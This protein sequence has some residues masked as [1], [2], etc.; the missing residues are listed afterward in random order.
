MDLNRKRE[1]D[2]KSLQKEL[3][4]TRADHGKVLGEVKRNH[5]TQSQNYDQNIDQLKKAKLK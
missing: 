2:L 1:Q 3:E 4:E 5:L